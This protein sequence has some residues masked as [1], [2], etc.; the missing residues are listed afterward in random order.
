MTATSTHPAG[1]GG[2]T[3]P[4]L[5]RRA[6]RRLPHPATAGRRPAPGRPPAGAPVVW[7]PASGERVLPVRGQR[8]LRAARPRSLSPWRPRSTG[9]PGWWSARRRPRA[10]LAAAS[11]AELG[12]DDH[13]WVHGT[14]DQ[15]RP[16][17]GRRRPPPPRTTSRSRRRPTL[18]WSP[19]ST[20]A[21]SSSS[22]WPAARLA[23]RAAR[24]RAGR[25]WWWPG[26]PSPGCGASSRAWHLLG[27]RPG[28]ARPLLG[29]PRR[30]WPRAVTHSVGAL[31]ARAGRRPDGWSRS[32]R[33]ARS[34]STA[35]PP[36]PCP[37]RSSPPPPP[38]CH[39]T[40]GN[41]PCH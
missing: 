7:T 1:R 2:R 4:R 33:T 34:P 27:R 39:L 36:H 38:C 37:P 9:R 6:G 31:T 26:P 30:R 41:P 23:H 12:A 20:S 22:S 11:T 5:A 29:P 40:E 19:W 32:P 8:R 13:G 14:R 35:S 10:G 18:R 17:P 3:P 16:R 28:R 25:S 24:R 15:V 21:A